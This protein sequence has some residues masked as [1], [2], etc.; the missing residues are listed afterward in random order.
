MAK[1]LDVRA[2]L[3]DMDGTAVDSNEI[4]EQSWAEVAAEFGLDLDVPLDAA[5]GKNVAVYPLRRAR[6][7]DETELRA[8]LTK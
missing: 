2:V 8:L 7:Q 6:L 5:W 1:S 3:I 4:V